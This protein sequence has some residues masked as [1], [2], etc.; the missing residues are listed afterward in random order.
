MLCNLQL[1]PDP[2]SQSNIQQPLPAAVCPSKE[3]LKA[4]P[5]VTLTGDHMLTALFT[6]LPVI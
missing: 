6:A 1:C 4:I 2:D 3:R 5:S